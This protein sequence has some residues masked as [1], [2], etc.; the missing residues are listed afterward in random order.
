MRSMARGYIRIP[1]TKTCKI[2]GKRVTFE[3]EKHAGYDR[4]AGCQ[5][6]EVTAK[7]GGKHYI[8]GGGCWPIG[9]RQ[10]AQFVKSLTCARLKREHKA[11]RKRLARR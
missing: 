3:V 6:I 9:E 11:L 4:V 1:D 8:V 5:L 10:K 7:V 2:D